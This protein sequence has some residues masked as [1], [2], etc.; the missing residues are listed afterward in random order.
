MKLL[1]ISLAIVWFF[2]AFSCSMEDDTIMNDV[3]SGIEEA[4]GEMYTAIDFGLSLTE[5]GTKSTSI[6][7][8]DSPDDKKP[9]DSDKTDNGEKTISSFDIFILEQNNIIGIIRNT[10]QVS[11]E[12][13]NNIT[14][15]S[16]EFVTKYKAGRT[17]KAYIVIN[18]TEYN[19]SGE[20][21]MDPFSTVKI[22]DG[23]DAINKEI[24]GHLTAKSLIKVGKKDIVMD[25]TYPKDP[26]P[27]AISASKNIHVTVSHVAARLDFNKFSCKLNGFAE[28]TKVQLLCAEFSNMQ[29]TGYIDGSES[30]SFNSASSSTTITSSMDVVDSFVN[31]KLT[32]YSYR[33]QSFDT[34]VQLYVKFEVN[35]NGNIRTFDKTYVINPPV[36]DKKVDHDYIMGGN[37]YDIEVNWTI[38]PS[39]SDSSI[40][41]YTRDWAYN[42][43]GSVDL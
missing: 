30:E 4:T 41:F 42:D 20:I 31:P 23:M 22:G 6:E 18:A 7:V 13:F 8:P 15:K 37:L 10:A 24:S 2:A 32:A 1:N 16:S 11:G 38:T 9:A 40:E 21:T 19:N 12:E 35:E 26:S 43:L 14:L 3:E 39:W 25:E 29:T 17:L 27:K 36:T 34:H 28:G 33:S 5:M